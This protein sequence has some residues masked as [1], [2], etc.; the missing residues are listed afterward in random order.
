MFA[1]YGKA[2]FPRFGSFLLSCSVGGGVVL[3][4]NEPREP[5]SAVSSS[6]AILSK[7][8]KGVPFVKRDFV[9]PLGVQILCLQV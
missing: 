1:S 5:F 6:G 4:L 2:A 3:G 8:F 9:L 7:G